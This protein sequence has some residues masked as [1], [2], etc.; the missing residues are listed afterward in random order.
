MVDFIMLLAENYIAGI[1]ILSTI[2]ITVYLVFSIRLIKSAR[3]EGLDVCTSCMIPIY[4]LS[5]WIR[6]C[7]RK[8]KNKKKLKIKDKNKMSEEIIL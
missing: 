3:K 4:N 6:K 5:V 2:V 1:T 8:R 7:I